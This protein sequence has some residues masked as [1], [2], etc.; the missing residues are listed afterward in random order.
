MT[1][2]ST[3]GHPTAPD[4]AIR[5]RRSRFSTRLYS[6]CLY[7]A[8]HAWL[9]RED[10]GIWRV[11]LTKFAARMLGDPVE[12]EFEVRDGDSVERGQE[13]G[14][15]EGFKAVSDIYT[16]I[17]GIF[18]GGNPTLLTD[19]DLFGRDPHREGWLFRIEGRPD[20]DCLDV[21]A[22]ASVLD[23]AIDKI[24]GTTTES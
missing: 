19:L 2:D 10:D 12:L 21:Q 11:G 6:D 20:D 8:A 5:Y 18:R 14:W 4:S 16:P 22:Y 7:T 15:V 9:R 17:P 23:A 24:M 1:N 3:T 13:V